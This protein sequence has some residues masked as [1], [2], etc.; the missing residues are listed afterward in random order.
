MSETSVPE[1]DPDAA[2]TQP[3]DDVRHTWAD[4]AEQLRAHQFAYHVK[5][6]PTISDGEYDALYREL[7]RL[8]QDYPSLRTPDSP[9]QQV[10][11][12]TFSTDFAAVTHRERML[13]L[14]N[15]FSPEELDGWLERVE[16]ETGGATVHYLC[17]LKIDGLA[18]NL[19]YDRGRLVRAA[20]RGDGT[21]GEDVTQNVRTIEG[22]PHQLRG[23]DVPEL[24][25]V[26][27][28][29]FMSM[30]DFEQLNAELVEA[31]KPPF[32][33]PRNTAAGSLRQKDPGS[34]PAARCACW[35]T[36]SA[37]APASTS[38][39]SPRRTTC[40]A[41]GACRSRPTPRS[42]AS[43]RRCRSSCAT[44]APTGTPSSTSS[45]GSWSR[46][47]RC[48]CS[49]RWGR[50]RARPGG[51]SRTSTRPRRST[52]RCSTSRSTS[53]APGA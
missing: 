39:A 11:G 19:L 4:L 41:S 27:G 18:I 22:I 33:N 40:C 9:T 44:P 50:P 7:D 25:E 6:A 37:P 21:T 29:V 31:G 51:R 13:S 43:R 12:A 46:S 28:E 34:P 52:P 47:T 49:V 38:P 45:T 24:V 14:D 32:A 15:V 48:R 2:A 20:T 30:S 26:R 8:E 23:D 1:A 10:G 36:A 53:D 16:R 3:P 17:E 35:C 5:D 42:S